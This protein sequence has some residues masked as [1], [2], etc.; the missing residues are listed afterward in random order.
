MKQAAVKELTRIAK[1]LAYGDKAT[2]AA[3][4]ELQYDT[5]VAAFRGQA[6]EKNTLTVLRRASKIVNDRRKK[7][8]RIDAIKKAVE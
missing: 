3:K 5:V 4:T 2:I 7:T 1:K 6:S 8:L